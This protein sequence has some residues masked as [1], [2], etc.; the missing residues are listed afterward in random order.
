MS[1][2]SLYKLPIRAEIRARI[3]ILSVSTQIFS[4]LN[5][6]QHLNS[7]LVQTSVL[8]FNLIKWIHYQPVDNNSYSS[9]NQDCIT[10]NPP[11]L[12]YTQD[13]SELSK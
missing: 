6:K 10:C 1:R 4:D 5:Y 8:I 9:N 7:F 2:D 12:V 11:V 3:C 13:S